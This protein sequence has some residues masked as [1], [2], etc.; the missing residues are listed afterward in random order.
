[1]KNKICKISLFSAVLACLV[2]QDTF[3]RVTVKKAGAG[4]YAS[5]YNQVN[6]IKQQAAYMEEQQYLA[7]TAS[8]T[9]TLP[10][11]VDDP[12]L[13]RSIMN[14]T[15]TMVSA[16]DLD[17]CSLIYPNGVFK[18][19][20]PESGI[21]KAPA[22]QCIA[23]VELRDANSNN[24]LATTTLAAGDSLKCNIDSFPESG[25]QNALGQV[26]L[27][28]DEAPTLED[29]EAALNQEQKQNAGIK[30]AAAALVGGLAGNFLGPKEAGN[31]KM[32]GTGKGQLTGTAIGAVSAAGV[33]AAST[34][35]GKVAGDTI[36]S[37]AVNAAAGAV[38]GNMAAGAS[39]GEA[40]LEI[41]KCKIKPAGSAS[42][43]TNAQSKDASSS[44]SEIELDCIPGKLRKSGESELYR[45]TQDATEVH[46]INYK[47]EVRTITLD[48]N[49]T[50]KD[51]YT[52]KPSDFL[53]NMYIGGK[54]KSEMKNTDWENLSVC[55]KYNPEADRDERKWSY[56]SDCTGKQNDSNVFYIIDSGNMGQDIRAYAVFDTHISDKMFG[57]KLSDWEGFQQQY[58]PSAYYQ[59]N[60]D[61]SVGSFIEY[62]IAID[63][64]TNQEVQNK[65]DQLNFRP[66]GRDAEDGGLVDMT[67]KA[68]MKGTL[69]GA[70]VGGALGGFTGYQ[71]AKQ[72]VIER[73][74]AATRE[75]NDSLTNFYCA[76]GKRF[77]SSYN[78]YAEIPSMS[79][80]TQTQQQQTQQ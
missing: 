62:R 47:G 56:V 75:Y 74:E 28:A 59:R 72:E 8:A 42:T 23:V 38:V 11:A 43:G 30:I 9:D 50:I 48:T 40:V 71:G 26:E 34:Y 54:A 77:L 61:G 19:G 79:V 33:M 80:V 27:P 66:S 14:N 57:W 53:I 15:S 70:G 17:N 39:G 6:A 1:M 29:A 76:T 78:S 3:A 65:S 64:T 73:W 55:Y 31:N 20:V 45:Y 21:R 4:N 49:R 22:Q 37:T 24:V 10:V 41:K 2:G 46:V 32:L 52:N 60:S 18:W 68:R 69:T 44:Q 35:S 25:W 16:V 5:A 51:E 63:K 36:K 13:A 67:N 12:E 58:Q 7:T